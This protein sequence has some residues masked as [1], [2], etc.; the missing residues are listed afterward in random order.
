MRKGLLEVAPPALPRLS[1]CLWPHEGSIRAGRGGALSPADA[2]GQVIDAADGEGMR[3]RGAR[4]AGVGDW[5]NGSVRGADRKAVVHVWVLETRGKNV[6]KRIFITRK[7]RCAKWRH[8]CV[9]AKIFQEMNFEAGNVGAV[10]NT[11]AVWNASIAVIE[12]MLW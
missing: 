7:R 5:S 1:P 11:A 4:W 9:S 6:G 12:C 8:V 10:V 3:V 2:V